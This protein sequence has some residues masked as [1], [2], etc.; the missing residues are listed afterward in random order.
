MN[1]RDVLYDFVSSQRPDVLGLAET[2]LNSDVNAQEVEI[3]GYSCFRCDRPS[4]DRGGV[5]LYIKSSLCGR[6]VS[7]YQSADGLCEQLWCSIHLR[8]CELLVGVVYRSPLSRSLDWLPHV[9]NHMSRP[10]FLLMGDFNLPR[11]QWPEAELL[12]GHCEVE[13]KFTELLF[14]TAATQHINQPTRITARATPSCLDLLLTSCEQ[15]V[16]N[17][18]VLEPLGA[19]DHSVI[20][21]SLELP[22]PNP[23]PLESTFNYWKADF[24]GLI[25]AASQID[26]SLPQDSS[27]ETCWAIIK[28]GVKS[29]CARFVPLKFR[30]VGPVK[31]HWF[32]KEYNKMARRRRRLWNKFVLSGSDEDYNAYKVQRNRCNKAKTSKRRSFEEELATAAKTAPKRIFAYVKRRLRPIA[33]IPVLEGSEGQPLTSSTDRA[34]ALATHFASVFASDQVSVMSSTSTAP[35]ELNSLDCN[36]EDVRKILANLDGTKP[37]GPDGIHPLILKSLSTIIAPS[38]TELFNRS[39]S[40]GLLPDDWKCSVVKPIPKGGNPSKVDNYRPICLTAVLA[41]TLEKIVKKSLLQLLESK[42]LLTSAQHGFL[43]GRSCI[44][45]LLL[46]RHEWL[47]ALNKGQSVDV[48]YIDFSKAFDK[49]NHAVLLDRLRMC[50][51]G[52]SLHKWISNFLIDRKWRVQVDNHLTDWYPSSSGVPQGTVLGPILFLIHINDVPQLLQSHCALF[53]D[54]LKVWRVIRTLNDCDLLQQDLDR[55]STWSAEVNLPINP[56]KSQ[57]MRLGKY[58]HGRTY[59]VAGQPLHP[60]PFVR[61]LG[62]LS[63]CDLKSI[64]NTNRLYQNSLRML[65]ALR[66]SFSTWSEEIATRLFVSIIRPMLEYGTPAYCPITRGE[67]EKLERVQH[68]ATRLIPNLRGMSYE[69]RCKKLGLYTLSYRRLRVDLIMTHRILHLGD[70]PML[71]QLLH[72]RTQSCTRGHRYKLIVPDLKRVA[73]QLCFERRVVNVWNDLP[74]HIVEANTVSKFKMLLDQ[75]FAEAKYKERNDK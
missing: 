71:R 19:S 60:A 68:V 17:I 46:T 51:V 53:A 58:D 27:I 8:R 63:R 7:A 22:L 73:H 16:H 67:V 26:W 34:S 43:K 64:D 61:D 55:L 20:I 28:E 74:Q 59:T 3:T 69:D 50:G 13:R 9:R 44:T 24:N 21:G 65:W 39:L 52:G 23:L 14:E 38:V 66:R 2:W 31:P 6:L 49:V 12:P 42:N 4:N 62:V 45:N 1:K 37:A 41:K 10:M 47:Q 54:D 11:I 36:I 33:N 5:L 18:Q 57:F 48:I 56:A 70:Y 40:T 75:Q 32:D 29:L 35:A 72:L 30:K 15:R 25:R